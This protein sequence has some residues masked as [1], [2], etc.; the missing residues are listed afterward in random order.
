MRQGR[1][2]SSTTDHPA[3]RSRDPLPILTIGAPCHEIER[4]ENGKPF[5][6]RIEHG[7]NTDRTIRSVGMELSVFIY[8]Y[9]W[10]IRP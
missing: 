1:K 5:E 6:P 10:L 7:S 8:V 3:Q 4:S 9:L 2:K